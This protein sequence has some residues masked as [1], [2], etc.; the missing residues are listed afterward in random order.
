MS[1]S[2]CKFRI[3]DSIERGLQLKICVVDS[4][5]ILLRMSNKYG[6][7]T[8]KVGYMYYFSLFDFTVTDLNAWKCFAFRMCLLA[9]PKTAKRGMVRGNSTGV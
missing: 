4:C 8:V 3:V 6:V 9:I 5:F 7:S 1:F 2:I